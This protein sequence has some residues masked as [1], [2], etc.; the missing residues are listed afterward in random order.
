MLG[1]LWRLQVGDLKYYVNASASGTPVTAPGAPAEAALTPFRGTLAGQR[2][3]TTTGAQPESHCIIGRIRLQR[4]LDL[5]LSE[6]LSRFKLRP[7]STAYR[8]CPAA[9]SHGAAWPLLPR[10]ATGSA[11]SGAEFY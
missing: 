7:N 2:D 5:N 1:P 6:S 8:R 3:S 10:S 11:A 4:Q 9:F